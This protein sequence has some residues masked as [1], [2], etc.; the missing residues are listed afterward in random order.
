MLKVKCLAVAGLIT[1]AISAK[2][3]D[4]YGATANCSL[5]DYHLMRQTVRTEYGNR[6]IR[7]VDGNGSE[8]KFWNVV[9]SRE[10]EEYIVVEKTISTGDG[11]D[12]GWYETV[13][14]NR[15][16]IG[17]NSEVDAG[18]QIVSYII[19]NPETN[20]C[21]DIAYVIDNEMIR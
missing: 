2:G 16:I 10:N 1:A 9:S 11:T 21:D 7:F 3:I 6:P 15:Y 5:D 18:K 12:H 19:W 20:E 4:V 13:D 8:E 17:Y 14:G